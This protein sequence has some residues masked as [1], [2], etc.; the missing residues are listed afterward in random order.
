[1]DSAAIA[2]LERLYG[3]EEP[4]AVSQPAASSQETAAS[5]QE[6]AASSQREDVTQHA[7]NPV[8]LPISSRPGRPREIA[9]SRFDVGAFV[10][11]IV[12]RTARD[13][14][15]LKLDKKML[16]LQVGRDRKRI[17]HAPDQLRAAYPRLM[18]ASAYKQFCKTPAKQ[19]SHN[20]FAKFLPLW[21]V[22]LSQEENCGAGKKQKDVDLRGAVVTVARAKVQSQLG[23]RGLVIGESANTLTIVTTE[24]R[25]RCLVK[26]DCLIASASAN[27]RR[28]LAYF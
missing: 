11:S 25:F 22:W 16:R 23:L 1:M 17:Q 8:Y 14:V 18:N 2:E 5:S 7:P 26:H 20:G 27:G 12:K 24:N 28:V 15:N 6:T 13:A 21:K 10:N 19:T 3:K 4:A 9:E